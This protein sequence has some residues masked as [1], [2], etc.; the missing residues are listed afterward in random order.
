MK[1][2]APGD[3]RRCRKRVQRL[4]RDLPAFDSVWIDAL[5]QARKLTPFQAKLL[6]SGDFRRLVV[7]PC[8]LVDRLGGGHRGETFLAQHRASR[9]TC[10]LKLVKPFDGFS[11]SEYSALEKTIALLNELRHPCL[12]GPQ[13]CDRLEERIVLVSR[14]VPGPHLAELL[15][16]RGRFPAAIVWEIGRQLLDGLATLHEHNCVHGD[17]RLH[18]VRLSDSGLA[19]LVDTGVRPIMEPD[20]TI[21]TPGAPERFDG[22]APEL[23]GTGKHQTPQTDL[24]A[25]GCLLWQLLAGRPPF[26]GG[27]P[28]AKIAFHQTQ[29][30]DDVREWAPETPKKLAEGIRA[31]TA[32]DPQSRPRT[33]AQVLERWKAPGRLQRGKVAKFVSGFR[34]VSRPA[35][36]NRVTSAAGRWMPVFILMFVMS[37]LV[38]FLTNQGARSVVLELVRDFRL[39][40]PAKTEDVTVPTEENPPVESAPPQ[41]Q[42]L[43]LPAPQEGLIELNSPGPYR[44]ARISVVGPLTIRGRPGIQPR[45]IVDEMPLRVSA[46]QV[47]LENLH[48]VRKNVSAA[49]TATGKAESLLLVESNQMELIGCSFQTHQLGDEAG[50][51]SPPLHRLG[52][53]PIAVGW[54]NLTSSPGG[55]LLVK[56]TLF[57]GSGSALQMMNA[58]A[59]IEV[60]N[61]LR[62]GEGALFVLSGSPR[63]GRR[64]TVLLNSVTCRNSGPLLNWR[65]KT[66]AGHHGQVRVEA[67]NC[68]YQPAGADVALVEFVGEDV[69]AEWPKLIELTGIDSIRAADSHLATWLNAQTAQRTPLSDED[70]KLEGFYAVPLVFEGAPSNRPADSELRELNTPI[71]RRSMELPGYHE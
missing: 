28:L 61:C 18:T 3:L 20:L 59:R 71:P 24:Y 57:L 38:A 54:R 43:E 17:V 4:A 8:L 30:I 67:V 26:P 34:T 35:G 36:K 58:P 16:R 31:L 64:M 48:L 53:K 25:I 63:P 33:A 14:Y 60:D 5:L 37:G 69:P 11:T 32:A 6:D 50:S 56:E 55:S 51:Q 62:L 7:G 46:Q 45:I 41:S 39:S 2:C 22:I 68:V 49:D 27:D 9:E 19:V 10:V 12:V 23:I 21:H 15:V 66:K 13:V 29:T 47:R 52:R 40:L 42:V 65:L 1:L 44:V 70:L